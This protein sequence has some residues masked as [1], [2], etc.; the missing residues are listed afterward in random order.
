MSNPIQEK[1]VHGEKLFPFASYEFTPAFPPELFSAHWHSD[2]EIIYMQKGAVTFGINGISYPLSAHQALMVNPY[3]IHYSVTANTPDF[4]FTSIVFGDSLVFPSTESCIYTRYIHPS[5]R[6]YI[7]FFPLLTP[8]TASG[9]DSLEHI[10]KI[11]LLAKSRPLCYE[12]EVQILLLSVFCNL[13]RAGTYDMEIREDFHTLSYVQEL[14][15]LLRKNFAEDIKLETLTSNMNISYEH[16]CRS[17]KKIVGKSP[18]KFLND[19]RI[20]HAV[21]LMKA[22]EHQAIAEIA[23]A[24]GFTDMSYFAKCF[25]QKTGRT[26]SEFRNRTM[27]EA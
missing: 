7:R 1:I 13:L 2:Y 10:D 18:K 22:S 27:P 15:Y 20:Q 21:Y 8:E 14:L 16:L 25:R 12:L 5:A 17:F 26:P 9:A 19:L 3:Q 11:C 6:E 24:C 4:C 23:E